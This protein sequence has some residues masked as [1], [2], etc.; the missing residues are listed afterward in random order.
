MVAM[1]F[2]HI[3]SLPFNPEKEISAILK[4]VTRE[5]AIKTQIEEEHITATWSF[6]PP[7]HYSVA[8]TGIRTQVL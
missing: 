3:Q 4:N 6:F 8:A 1:P 2:V 7:H 5:F